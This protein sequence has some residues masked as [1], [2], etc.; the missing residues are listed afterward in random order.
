[1]W[2]GGWCY[3][4]RLLFPVAVLLGFEGIVQIS[5]VRFS[6]ILFLILTGFGLL[7]AFL[8][9]VTVVYSIPSESSNPFFDTIF[10]NIRLENFNPNNLANMIFGVNPL[11]SGILWFGI[12]I[13]SIIVLDRFHK[14]VITHD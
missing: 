2:W 11:I 13:L 14:K 4:P 6:R 1:V 8:A 7:G 12:F 5:N 9:K 3:G 10:P